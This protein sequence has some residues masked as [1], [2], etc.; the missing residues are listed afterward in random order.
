MSRLEEW[1]RETEAAALARLRSV[2]AGAGSR[3]LLLVYTR[4]S[5]SDFDRDGSARGP[6]LHQQLAAVSS[7]P[8]LQGLPLELFQDADRSGKETSRRP[9]YLGLMER[10]R[11]AP[12]GAIGAIAFYDVDRLH[13]NDL[14]FFRF[15]AEMTERQI[16]VFDANGLVS[17]VDRLSWKIKAIVAQEE[18]EKVARRVK[19]NLHYLR[20][21]G[22]LLG[23]LPQGYR[24]AAGR[25]VEDPAA[26][27]VIREIFR[28]YATGKYSF[29]TLADQLNRQGVKPPRG[30]EKINH[31]RPKAVIFT[32]DV[33]KDIVSNPSYLGKVS[34]D[35]ELIQGNHPAL[36]DEATWQACQEVRERNLR[37][38][39][40]TWTRHNYPL[41][42]FLRCGRCG[43]PMHGEAS[44]KRHR[45]D[46]YYACHRS[47]RSR[48]AVRPLPSSCDARWIPAVFL[49]CAVRDELGRCVPT[50]EAN[51]TYRGYLRQVI[52]RGPKREVTTQA[53]SRRLKE[54]LERVR[55][56]YEF[57]EYDWDTFV[58]KRDEIRAEQS[59]LDAEAGAQLGTTDLEWC[60]AQLLDLLAAWDAASGD[61]RTRLLAGIFDG[62]EVEAASDGRVR[63]VAVP[64]EAWKRFF[65]YVVLERETGFE[66]ATSTLARL[67]STK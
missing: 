44:R 11:T 7:R 60:E 17:N 18:R 23:L 19:D 53:A 59:R 30:P 62:I 5:V 64:K 20:R 41:T 39:S 57:G 35:G 10:V 36:V 9:G 1:T 49:E 3:P 12:A 47:R 66:P 28:L 13:R 65:E 8:E 34:V 22:H 48:S 38:T 50:A 6:S 55:R 16:L 4:Q 27:P 24:R 31:N 26:G 43:A 63:V 40:K 51:R 21:N 46:L 45:V 25:I 42:P 14:E 56:L 54:Q 67:R 32:R 37:R 33:L 2:A 58:A 52:A 29:S 61:Q 15:M